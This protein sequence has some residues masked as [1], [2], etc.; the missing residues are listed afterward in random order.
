MTKEDAISLAKAH[1]GEAAL[2]QLSSVHA[3]QIDRDYIVNNGEHIN[4]LRTGIWKKMRLTPPCPPFD[5]DNVVPHWKV[6]GY[7]LGRHDGILKLHV[8]SIEVHDDGGIQ[9]FPAYPL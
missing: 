4:K 5:E 2:S 6:H 9:E 1:L 7:D 3:T 8:I